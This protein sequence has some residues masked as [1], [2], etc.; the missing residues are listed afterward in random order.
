[1]V[2][3]PFHGLLNFS[4]VCPQRSAFGCTLGFILS[5]ACAGFQSVSKLLG[6][7]GSLRPADGVKRREA[8]VL[9]N[10]EVAARGLGDF[11][12]RVGFEA[13]HDFEHLADGR[14]P[15]RKVQDVAFVFQDARQLAQAFAQGNIFEHAACDHEIERFVGEGQRQNVRLL[16]PDLVCA[17]CLFLDSFFGGLD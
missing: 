2:C 13:E 8:V 7:H 1:M 16:E 10:A 11:A 17:P 6:Q 3:R 12:R 9:D 14:W 5:P 4:G 15:D